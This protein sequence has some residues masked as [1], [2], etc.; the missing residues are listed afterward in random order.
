MIEFWIFLRYGF[1]RNAAI[2]KNHNQEEDLPMFIHSS[3]GMFVSIQNHYN[4][5]SMRSRHASSNSKNPEIS[6]E[7]QMSILFNRQVAQETSPKN[8]ANSET[9]SRERSKSHHIQYLKMNEKTMQ[10]KASCAADNDT[11]IGFSWS[12]NFMLGKR[13]RSQFTGDEYYQDNILA[14]FR[15]F[16]SNLD[17]RLF[18]FYTECKENLKLFRY[19]KS[20]K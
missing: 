13:W 6:N 10:I 11:F 3:G 2:L 18:K 14:D 9:K 1:I 7:E 19:A 8:T 20:F 4:N 16:C 5:Y 17:G 15:L 12:W